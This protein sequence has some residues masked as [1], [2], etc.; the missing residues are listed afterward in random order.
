MTPA[1]TVQEKL[2]SWHPTDNGR[3][4]LSDN[5][6][7]LGWIMKLTADRHDSIG[8]LVW[9]FEIH[10]EALSDS[11]VTMRAWAEQIVDRVSGLMENL[12]IHEIDK[13]SQQALLRSDE[14]NQRGDRLQY[15]EV[16][17]FGTYRAVV[18]RFQ[19]SKSVSGREQ[20]A[21]ALTHDTLAK[22]VTDI[23]EAGKDSPS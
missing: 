23:A 1:E 21:Y 9:E 22:L 18:R 15:F 11:K 20:I 10:R 14:P 17:L 12:A 8:T 2:A 7:D 3:Q 19:S 5:I 16:H 13:T 4:Q 6:A